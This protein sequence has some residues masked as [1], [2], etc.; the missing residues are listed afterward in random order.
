MKRGRMPFNGQLEF[1]LNYLHEPYLLG[2]EASSQKLAVID[3]FVKPIFSVDR[4][5]T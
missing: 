4:V 2:N 5:F 1:I 3:T